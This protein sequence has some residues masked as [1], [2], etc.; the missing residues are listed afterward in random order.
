MQVLDRA[1]IWSDHNA[2]QSTARQ[3]QEIDRMRM[4][5][6]RCSSLGGSQTPQEAVARDLGA[7]VAIN[8]HTQGVNPPGVRLRGRERSSLFI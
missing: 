2:N 3:D 7:H 5:R 4:V 1:R 6:V 8:E